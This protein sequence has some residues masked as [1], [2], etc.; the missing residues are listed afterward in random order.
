MEDG[1]REKH[2]NV[3]NLY[4]VWN[5]ESDGEMRKLVNVGVL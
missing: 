2:W 5:S 1:L 4:N 3:Q